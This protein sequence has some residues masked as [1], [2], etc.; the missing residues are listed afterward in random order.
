MIKKTLS[1]RI[2][3]FER[4]NAGLTRN[5]KECCIYKVHEQLRDISE[6]AYK[7]VLLAIGPYNNQDNVGNGFMEE[8]KLRYLQQMLKRTEVSLQTYITTLEILEEAA[9]EFVE[10]MVLDGCFIIELFHNY[11][12]MI[13]WIMEDDPIFQMKWVLPRIAHDLLLFENQL[14]LFVLAK[15]F[16][17]NYP[18]T[19]YSSCPQFFLGVGFKFKNVE[20]EH[21][22]G[23]IHTTICISLLD[24]EIDNARESQ[25][26]RVKLKMLEIFKHLF[27]PRKAISHASEFQRL[28]PQVNMT[29]IEENWEAIPFGLE[30]RKIKQWNVHSATELEEAGIKFKKAEKSNVFSLK[31]NNG[32]MEIST[33][34]MED[35][36]ET[37]LRNLIA[38]EQYCDRQ[39]G[40]TS[41]CLG[42][43]EII[44]TMVNKLGHYINYSTN[45]YARTSANLNMHCRRCCN[46]WMAK[47]RHDYFNNPW[48]LVSFLGA[49][50]LLALAIT[51]TIFS[52]IN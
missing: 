43:D 14:P 47:L 10:M 16:E 6:K 13:Y 2:E 33:L 8:H 50:L 48:A 41:N 51:Q 40:I 1:T 45:I 44:S 29:K 28:G 42:D 9:H 37:Y 49:V 32:L 11:H 19:T 17:M 27:G 4:K 22:L 34:M 12:E 24:T 38:Y 23:L 18:D 39:N 30:L 52:I 25:E 31:F 21:L 36:T 7:P 35:D 3:E 15:L 46:V 20:F 26:A 5:A